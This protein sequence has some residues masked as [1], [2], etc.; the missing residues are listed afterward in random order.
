M[1]EKIASCRILRDSCL[2][3]WE[4]GVFNTRPDKMRVRGELPA[5]LP[6]RTVR[7]DFPHTALHRVSPS[8]REKPLDPKC[9]LR[10]DRQ[11]IPDPVGETRHWE[12]LRPTNHDRHGP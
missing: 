11:E 6:S 8:G 3:P 4:P 1:R 12:Q 5:P 10:P 2:P 9:T 7:A